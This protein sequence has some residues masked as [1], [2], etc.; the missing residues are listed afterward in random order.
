MTWRSVGYSDGDGDEL[1]K[2][3][4]EEGAFSDR[5]AADKALKSLAMRYFRL[6]KKMYDEKLAHMDDRLK[7]CCEYDK[8]KI[9]ITYF[10]DPE[11]ETN[12][13]FTVETLGDC[14]WGNET[15]IFEIISV[16]LDREKEKNH[17]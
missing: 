15:R 3:V 6:G 11:T 14:S 16:D 17:G 9:S 12:P 13:I 1:K 2:I 5:I 7:G 8:P 4:V 10:D